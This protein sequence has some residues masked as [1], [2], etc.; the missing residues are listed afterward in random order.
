MGATGSV[1]DRRPILMLN[2]TP[3][4]FYLFEAEQVEQF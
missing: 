4:D 1:L 3:T 2:Y